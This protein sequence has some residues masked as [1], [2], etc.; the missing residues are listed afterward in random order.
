[1]AVVVDSTGNAVQYE[2]LGNA[3]KPG[4]LLIHGTGATAMSNWGAMAGSFSDQRRVLLPNY[5]GSGETRDNGGRLTLASLAAQMLAVAEIESAGPVDVVGFS[6]GAE[7][8]ATLAAL[9]PGQVRRLILIAGWSSSADPRLALGIQLW[10]HLYES[11]LSAFRT[12]STLLG[13]SP[14]FLQQTG[15]AG[16]ALLS[17]WIPS[18]GVRRQL[19]LDL[20]IDLRPLLPNITAPTLVIGCTQDQ[21][22]PVQNARALHEAIPH[23]EYQEFD[24]GH[25]LILE[26]APGLT[27]A[28]RDFLF[29]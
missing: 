3:E 26:D 22:V 14:A 27:Q 16:I 28:I 6:L 20:E 10:T 5:S 13:F 23:S 11:D 4:L 24:T 29:K 7:V 1:M 25:M 12:L 8:A 18:S 9:H 15:P 21:L 17:R 19:A 2:A